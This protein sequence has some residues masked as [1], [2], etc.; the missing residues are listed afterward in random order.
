MAADPSEMAAELQAAVMA[1][2]NVQVTRYVGVA[3]LVILLYDHALSLA[4]EVE[5]VWPAK[6]TIAKVLF[7]VLRYIVPFFLTIHITLLSGLS[8]IRMSNSIYLGWSTVLISNFL[9]LLRIYT[10]IP[11]RHKVVVWTFSFFVLVQVTSFAVTTW[12]IV[13]MIPLI[14]FEPVAR[15]C[16]FTRKPNFAGLWVVGLAFEIVI[17]AIT[18]WNA[19]DRPRTMTSDAA[20][21][22]MLFRDGAVYFIVLFVLRTANT[23]ISVVAPVSLLFVGVFIIWAGATITTSRLIINSRK[24]A[25]QAILKAQARGLEVF[26]P[27]EEQASSGRSDR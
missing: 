15:L 18:W 7:L 6:N 14:S 27:S 24:T 20:V 26:G 3:G 16:T 2:N 8:D 19:L 11:R 4:D 9:V 10:I 23:V 21:T 17:F 25:R 13:N 12:T 1:L 5:Y 22:K